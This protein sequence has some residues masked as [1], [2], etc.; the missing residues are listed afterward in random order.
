VLSE[1]RHFRRVKVYT[2]AG[3]QELAKV[4][5]LAPREFALENVEARTVA[6]D[7][8]IRELEKSAIFR[9]TTFKRKGTE[10]RRVTFAPP[11]VQAGCVVE[12]AWRA[13]RSGFLT[14]WANLPFQDERFPIRK[15]SYLLRPVNLPGIKMRTLQF[16]APIHTGPS[17]DG[18][19]YELTS[20]NLPAFREEYAMPP[21]S[22]ARAFAIVY[23]VGTDDQGN[24]DRDP[25]TYWN[26]VGKNA[27][28]TFAS[29]IKPNN[30][31]KAQAATILE[32]ASPLSPADRLFDW[33]RRE[34]RIVWSSDSD[35]LEAAGLAVNKSAADVL[36]QR[37]GT[38]D[39][40]N[41][42]FASLAEASGMAVRQIAV[43]PRT[44]MRFTPS[45]Y[46]ASFLT[47]YQVAVQQDSAWLSYDIAARDLP[48][49]MVHW[50]EEDQAGLL[51]LPLASPLVRT[52]L[53]E[54]GFSTLLRSADL[55][56][57]ADGKLT[58]SLAC[59]F[60]GHYNQR[61]R[62]YLRDAES[63]DEG[64]DSVE[65]ATGAR[66][67]GDTWKDVVV[68]AGKV[69]WEPLRIRANVELAGRA[70]MSGDRL[71][72]QPSVIEARATPEFTDSKR[73]HPV[74]FAFA[75]VEVDSVRIHL[76]E[77][78][79]I[80]DFSVPEPFKTAAA[81]YD[82][83]LL[84]IDNGR[85]LLYVRSVR[86]GD[87]GRLYFARSNYELVQRTWARMH[88]LDGMN[89]VLKRSAMAGKTP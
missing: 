9:E 12:Y 66:L 68:D 57:A 83:N 4:E 62:A 18:F 75:G 89:V 52:P 25:A 56:L 51:C 84:T 53:A 30:T 87:G 61:A 6:P 55:V 63:L 77:G 27:A 37:G 60:G 47:S 35:S 81:A 28:K 49:G 82:A 65:V 80:E 85:G 13:R 22:Q 41:R 23:Y 15:V 58:G 32:G 46:E 33:C 1:Q 14:H 45:L 86:V 38:A 24:V 39:D 48:A 3:A 17:K 43:C 50:S 19:W 42:L 74:E 64:K 73:R 78:W 69:T 59:S 8:T 54:P 40:A 67:E 76:P 70:S 16:N 26:D 71:L 7:G 34:I 5:L 29:W 88:E 72:L 44:T 79:E 21:E 20:E 36:K 31:I 11:A 10:L 2:E